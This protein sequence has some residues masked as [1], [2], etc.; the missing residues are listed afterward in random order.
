MILPV[1]R[2]RV[3]TTALLLFFLFP[4]PAY[5]RH[6]WTYNSSSGLSNNLTVPIIP[7]LLNYEINIVF[8]GINE[9]RI[10][11]DSLL[12]Q[13]PKWYAPVDGMWWRQEFDMNFTLAYSLSF[14][15]Q[16]Q[17]DD[18]RMFLHQ[19]SVEDRSPFF[20]QPEHPMA[21]Y[22]HSDMVESYLAENVIDKSSATLVIIDTYSFDPTGHVPY[23]YN[24]TYN[25]LDAE[26]EGW[27]INP[28]PWASTYQIA[29]GGENSRLLW[30]D[31]SAGPTVYHST[32]DSSTG[33]VEEI[34]PIWTYE[35]LVNPVEQ[36][37]EDLVKYI[38]QA[39][40]CR[41]SP[42]TYLRATIGVPLIHSPTTE[43][44][45]E[46][47]LVDLANTNF[48]F[49][50][51]LKLD[52]IASEYER[53]NPFVEWTYSVTDWDWESDLSFLS[54]LEASQDDQAM[55]YDPR[56]LVEFFDLKYMSLFNS[57]SHNRLVLPIFLLTLPVGWNFNPEWGGMAQCIDGE[58]AYI[59]GKQSLD[60]VDPSYI[61][62]AIIPLE[63]L[64]IESGDSFNISGY[65][66]DFIG[67]IDFSMNVLNSRI[68]VYFLD[69][70]GYNQYEQALPFVD[71]LNHSFENVSAG[72][73]MVVSNF[74]CTIYGR[75]YLVIE[76]NENETATVDITL[77]IEVDHCYGYTWKIMHEIGH[78]LGL[79]HPHDAYSW[80]N[81]NHPAA[82]V[83]VYLNWLWDMSYSQMNYAN[84]VPTI[85]L[86]DIDTL[87]RESI[88]RYW[89]DAVNIWND[90]VN[91]ST[92]K[93]GGVSSIIEMHLVNASQHFNQSVDYY[94]NTNSL[95]N[96]QNSLHEVFSMWKELRLALAEL[97]FYSLLEIQNI[98]F[99]VFVVAVIILIVVI[100][101]VMRR[102][103]MR[104]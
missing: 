83:G 37:T 21:K 66:G 10:D 72:S 48:R 65:L 87:Q 98:L 55:T 5:V 52:Y 54:V 73:G 92:I 61:D 17:I 88:T 40:E 85:S 71:L 35:E 53:V 43:I 59:Y 84:Q 90:I 89:A 50:E 78:A 9:T 32:F 77:N 46:V 16:V 60:L 70:Y 15:E 93:Y 80:G 76:N 57:S 91:N 74:E 18:Y 2:R 56:I 101:V 39:V 97:A 13:L 12:D 62:Q 51:R 58:F 42:S 49:E 100:Y 45:M 104:E 30:L 86:M 24:A 1:S 7:N 82:N 26:L 99:I 64:Q 20:I 28:L 94:S 31:L 102:R 34:L 103:R 6:Q 8:L 96:Y 19:N 63:G 95:D 27:V 11:Q 25:E 47:L 81:Y 4:V 14:T 3:W 33:G 29:G 44:A 69:E 36:L 79:N 23:Y 75:Y 41:F 67:S 68:S 38:T 22:I